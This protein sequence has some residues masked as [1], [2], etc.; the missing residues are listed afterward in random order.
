MERASPGGFRQISEDTVFEGT[1]IRVAVGE[2]VSPAG[3]TVVR[4]L[5][6]HPG[7]VSVVPIVDGHVVMRDRRIETVD[8]PA[9]LKAAAAAGKDL[10]RRLG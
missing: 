6:R 3:D 1:I 8:E 5:V 4:E 2:F 10:V 9:I 7:A